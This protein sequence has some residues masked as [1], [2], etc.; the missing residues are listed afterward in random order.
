MTQ[1]D[2]SMQVGDKGYVG[3]EEHGVTVLCHECGTLLEVH[4][5]AALVLTLHLRNDCDISGL[6]SHG[7]GE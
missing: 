4:D 3:H 6:F 5:V 2:G 7:S 1:P